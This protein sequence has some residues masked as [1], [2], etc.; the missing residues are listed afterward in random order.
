MAVFI[1]LGLAY[2]SLILLG[3]VFKRDYF[4]V[5][6]FFYWGAFL[7]IL[8]SLEILE[9]R[10]GRVFLFFL[11][12]LFLLFR[13]MQTKVYYRSLLFGLAILINGLLT[14]QSIALGEE[15]LFHSLF[16]EKYEIESKEYTEWVFQENSKLLTNKAIPLE[17]QVPTGLF[18]HSIE[19]LSLKNKTGSGQIAGIL[20]S[21]EKDPNIYPYIRIFVISGY[22]AINTSTIKEEYEQVLEFESKKG[23]MENLEY[24]QAHTPDNQPTWE[25][26][27]WKF[28]D[29]LRPRYTK[30]GFYLIKKGN[31]V[32]LV[33]DIR[34]NITE[35]T[36]HEEIIQNTLDS[37]K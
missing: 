24:L 37:F 20:S 18:F 17:I 14:F 7:G 3:W 13:Q 21:S 4:W 28:F 16:R 23:E 36:F 11:F 2:L 29:R 8:Y 1:S 33:L 19:N 10:G 5:T 30:S 34:E 12:L 25:G 15:Y 9:N 22:R 31:G 27:F 32:H 6:E 26:S 35:N